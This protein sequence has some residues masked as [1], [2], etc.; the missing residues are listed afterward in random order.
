MDKEKTCK[1]I[2]VIAVVLFVLVLFVSIT[3]TINY[4]NYNSQIKNGEVEGKSVHIDE[5]EK[6]SYRASGKTK[7]K[8]TYIFDYEVDGV[9]Y[10]GSKTVNKNTI[11]FY[12]PDSYKIFYDIE[13]PAEY[14]FVEDAQPGVFWYWTLPVSSVIGFFV[15][16]Y[17]KNSY[18]Y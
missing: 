9:I 14:F 18:Y 15:A 3:T 17:I 6:V 7:Y 1:G 5:I 2:M 16:R 13:D 8:Y 12:H 10:E 4:S 11:P